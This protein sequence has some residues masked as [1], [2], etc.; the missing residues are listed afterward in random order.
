MIVRVQ[1]YPVAPPSF[2]SFLDFERDADDL[3]GDFLGA[4]ALPVRRQYPAL[5]VAGY[6]NESVVV[7]EIPGVRKEDV[8]I[9]VQDGMLTISGERKEPAAPEESTWLRNEIRTGEF[10]RTMELP[11][12]VDVNAIEAEITNGV[13]RIVLPKAAE[14]RS[15]EIP[16]K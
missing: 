12:E 5:D 3:F 14:A 4:Q 2:A 11:H 16:V 15:R 10:S 6:E 8:K 9:S 7:A 13:L 1:R